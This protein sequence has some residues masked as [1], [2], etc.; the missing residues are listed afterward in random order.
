MLKFEK[1]SKTRE[2]NVLLRAKPTLLTAPFLIALAYA[3]FVHLAAFFLF[4]VAPQNINFQYT[5]FSPVNVAV[6]LPVHSGV[7]V[8][9]QDEEPVPEYLIAPSPKIPKLPIATGTPLVR[10]LEYI[11]LQSPLNNFFLD[12]ENSIE[13]ETKKESSAPLSVYLSGSIADMSLSPM[14][15]NEVLNEIALPRG[16]MDVASKEPN[17]YL[18]RVLADQSQGEIFWWEL[19]ESDLSKTYYA[20]ALDVLKNLQFT[21]APDLGILSGEVEIVIR[22]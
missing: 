15:L 16:S 5:L 20:E 7:Y 6:E 19:I 3:L 12:F 22:L 1:I 14:K 2:L 21:P 8:A 4:K 13:L 10:N 11:K 18:F 9:L 17:R